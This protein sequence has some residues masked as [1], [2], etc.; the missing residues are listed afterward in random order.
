MT[1]IDFVS[2]EQTLHYFTVFHKY[3]LFV[4]L[5]IQCSKKRGQENLDRLYLK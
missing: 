1:Q 4:L 5:T 3:L 2:F